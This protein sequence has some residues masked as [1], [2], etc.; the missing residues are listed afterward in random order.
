MLKVKDTFYEYNEE[1]LRVSSVK[2]YTY[3]DYMSNSP[4]RDGEE[5]CSFLNDV[6]KKRKEK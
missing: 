2:N 3:E 4:M 6:N 1:L 5:I